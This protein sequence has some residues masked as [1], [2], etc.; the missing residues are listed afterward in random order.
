LSATLDDQ[1][2]APAVTVDGVRVPVYYEL[3]DSLSEFDAS[4][5]NG[6]A[7][8]N[9]G[10]YRTEYIFEKKD[11][12]E[13]D[14]VRELLKTKNLKGSVRRVRAVD[15]RPPDPTLARDRD[16]ATVFDDLPGGD[17]PELKWLLTTTTGRSVMRRLARALLRVQQELGNGQRIQFFIPMVENN[18]QV[19][20]ALEIL[21]EAKQSLEDEGVLDR[22]LDVT[23][24]FGV[25]I[26]SPVPVEELRKIFDRPD[27]AVKFVSIGSRDMADKTNMT[28]VSEKVYLSEFE[29]IIKTADAYRVPVSICGVNASNEEL[30]L[31]ALSVV[32]KNGSVPSFTMDL[33]AIPEIK[34][35]L[36]SVKRADIQK[37]FAGILNQD[38]A[39]IA[40]QITQSVQAVR[41]AVESSAKDS[42][43]YEESLHVATMQRGLVEAA[44]EDFNPNAFPNIKKILRVDPIGPNKGRIPSR[45]AGK[46]GF[47]FSLANISGR[48]A[49]TAMAYTAQNGNRLMLYLMRIAH[50]YTLR[51]LLGRDT[52]RNYVVVA[53]EGTRLGKLRQSI[54]PIGSRFGL[55]DEERQIGLLSVETP[56]GML[57]RDGQ[58]TIVGSLYGENGALVELPDAN[59]A[60]IVVR[61][62]LEKLNLKGM[63]GKRNGDASVNL[64][65]IARRLV[66]QA[67]YSLKRPLAIGIQLRPHHA[68]TI[69]ALIQ[70]LKIDVT[71]EQVK[72]QVENSSQGWVDFRSD[73]GNVLRVYNYDD[74]SFGLTM[75]TLTGL[76]AYLGIGGTPEAMMSAALVRKLGG[77]MVATLVPH[78]N[79]KKFDVAETAVLNNN[80]IRN[81]SRVYSASDLVRGNPEDL[82]V[83]ISVLRNFKLG[84]EMLNGPRMLPNGN[85]EAHVIWVSDAELL[86]VKI[87]Y[88]TSV[89]EL[90]D[91]QKTAPLD[92]DDS[93]KL[94]IGYTELGQW[95][96]ASALVQDMGKLSD[97]NTEM[98]A[99]WQVLRMY[100]LSSRNLVLGAG[101]ETE[102]SKHSLELL[103]QADSLAREAG[104]SKLGVQLRL[105]EKIR[106][107]SYALRDLYISQ[108]ELA[109]PSASDAFTREA[110]KYSMTALEHSERGFETLTRQH[111][112][113]L[114]PLLK[115]YEQAINA[116]VSKFRRPPLDVRIRE[117]Y[118]VWQDFMAETEDPAKQ[119][120]QKQ[121]GDYSEILQK[122][123]TSLWSVFFY[124]TVLSTE[125]LDAQARIL[126]FFHSDTTARSFVS[127]IS[128]PAIVHKVNRDEM[129][130][131]IRSMVNKGN[132]A[133][134]WQGGGL[135]ALRPDLM[136]LSDSIK[137]LSSRVET[138]EQ[139]QIVFPLLVLACLFKA[140]MM[141]TLGA[142][143]RQL[144]YMKEAESFASVIE[145]HPL[146]FSHSPVAL[147]FDFSLLYSWLAKETGEQRY[148]EKAAFYETLTQ[149][150]KHFHDFLADIKKNNVRAFSEEE[151]TDT[152][153]PQRHWHQ[154][155]YHSGSGMTSL[156]SISPVVL[157]VPSVA[158]A[159][160][161]ILVA[162]KIGAYAIRRLRVDD[163]LNN[164]QKKVYASVLGAL[165]TADQRSVLGMDLGIDSS[166]N[167]SG[168][169]WHRIR[170]QRALRNEIRRN[171][172]AGTLSLS[173]AV[174]RGLEQT[175]SGIHLGFADLADD[176]SWKTVTATLQAMEKQ[177][178]QA[179]ELDPNA[180]LI[181]FLLTLSG[182][183]EL[184]ISRIRLQA[185]RKN[186]PHVPIGIQRLG[187]GLLVLRDGETAYRYEDLFKAFA[188]DP[189]L[190]PYADVLRMLSHSELPDGMRLMESNAPPVA[191]TANESLLKAILVLI[192]LEGGLGSVLL[193][194]QTALLASQNA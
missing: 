31:F 35:F 186:Y 173:S 12:S 14:L 9:I 193:D 115:N 83:S 158:L 152:F 55:G 32:T 142:P 146:L 28:A 91:K 25:M 157:M 181:P 159:V 114:S 90:L 141:V 93:I 160:V 34:A 103:T 17:V 127:A 37:A 187:E 72:E 57:T 51:L 113:Y 126:R 53:A 59:V 191:F 149:S 75:D 63:L 48:H 131:Q 7:E 136:F 151:I 81:L 116:Y 170:F 50:T 101:S 79:K 11:L 176:A 19:S 88:E 105:E 20:A 80:G 110:I 95:D 130:D 137:A 62:E 132:H 39:G 67:G 107:L 171:V 70:Q 92:L 99:V 180:P 156:H 121:L 69:R 43:I 175:K 6:A 24:D 26:E 8:G 162:W 129:V 47:D 54:L 145:M 22:T 148:K 177:A 40:E 84:E 23:L 168:S 52:R 189:A 100:V 86:P 163:A 194:M 30:I 184:S 77:R 98:A 183:A 125:S 61:R 104:L 117:A 122:Q 44:I 4:R 150:P 33:H 111:R 123:G 87:T 120:L 192:S 138:R 58:G 140:E 49:L 21:K 188:Q 42:K 118:R 102:V 5:I 66:K 161:A 60:K 133:P 108:S 16:K 154:S 106:R 185:L 164:E 165:E 36:R 172:T 190:E 82:A 166:L 128:N 38:D 143:E 13:D 1:K 119:H 68:E 124:L 45:K 78:Q 76:D 96:A 139:A 155:R 182:A 2:A 65:E 46:I 3:S 135:P 85:V 73:D 167:V 89:S 147:I 10:L 169:L 134:R 97:A 112:I 179:R 71:Y 18:D 178:I 41:D 94:I 64:P 109:E 56:G 174:Q 27:R 15:R 29:K 144:P 74:W 153:E